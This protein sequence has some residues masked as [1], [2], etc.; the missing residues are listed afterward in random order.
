MDRQKARPLSDLDL[1]E[2]EMDLLGGSEAGPELVL[3]CA[4]DGM[5]ARIRKQPPPETARM[6]SAEIESNASPGEDPS[7]PPTQLEPCRVLLEDALGA[8]VRLAP[9]SGP[10]YLIEPGVTFR[11]SA[12]LVRSDTRDPTQLRAANPGHWGA[13][14]WQDLVN[15]RLGPWVMARQGERVISICHTPVGKCPCC[16]GGYLDA[17]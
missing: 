3:A 12:Q 11:S 13:D 15:G 8:A 9:N 16:R 2:I 17:S 6:V 1:L 7:A 4:R 5:R 10:S 14:E